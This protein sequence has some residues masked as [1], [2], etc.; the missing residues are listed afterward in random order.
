MIQKI[1]LN[2]NNYLALTCINCTKTCYM[3]KN[4]IDDYEKKNCAAFDKKGNCIYCPRRCSYQYHNFRDYIL[5]DIFEEKTIILEDL[6]KRY[7]YSQNQL[8]NENQ[9][10]NRTK[11]EL[12]RINTEFFEV[13]NTINNS[14]N[15]LNEIA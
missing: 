6:K 4:I 8:S 7:Y 10:F 11:D 13:L 3:E 9:L 5:K 12:N 1:N 2:H 14:I 15:L